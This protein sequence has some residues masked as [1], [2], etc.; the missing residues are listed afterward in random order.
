MTG[1]SFS[2]DGGKPEKF[3]ESDGPN[4]YIGGE[5]KTKNYETRIKGFELKDDINAKKANQE[6]ATNTQS[7]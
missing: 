6:T 3:G 1:D 7:E 5:K 4:P 2:D